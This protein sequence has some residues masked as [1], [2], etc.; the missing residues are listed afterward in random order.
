MKLKIQSIILVTVIL[1]ISVTNLMTT[2][3]VNLAVLNFYSDTQSNLGSGFSET[4]TE[5]LNK[6]ENI[7]VLEREKLRTIMSEIGMDINQKFDPSTGQTIGK[8]LGVDYLISGNLKEDTNQVI[9]KFQLF[10]VKDGT[11]VAEESVKGGKDKFF[12]LQ[13]QL[14]EKVAKFFNISVSEQAKKDLYFIP[15]QDMVSFEKFSKGLNLYEGNCLKEA[16]GFFHN[17]VKVDTGFLEAHKYFE[18]TARK[19]GKLDEFINIYENM[20]S[21]DPQNPILLNYLGNAYFDKKDMVK[22]ESL[23]KKAIEIAPSFGNPYNNLASVYAL[24]KR[25]KEAL[26]KFE[27]ALK[28]SDKKAPVYNN[29]GICYLNLGDENNAIKYFKKV[30]EL[31]PK[32]PDFIVARVKVQGINILVKSREKKVPGGIFGEIVLNSAPVFEIQT[33]AGG[34]SPVERSKI[35]AERLQNMITEG[36]KSYQV[37]VGLMN[38][39]VVLQS[40]GGEL[41]MTITKDVATR[42]GTT[43]ENLAK[44]KAEILKKIL[45]YSTSSSLSAG[46]FVLQDIYLKIT[47]ETLEKLKTEIDTSRLTKLV[48]KEMT[49]GKMQKELE[50]LNFNNDEIS[51]II[52][53]STS[54][55]DTKEMEGT[56]KEADCLHRGDAYYSQGNI[57]R[58]SEEYQKALTINPSFSPAQFCLGIISFDQKD[59]ENAISYFNKAIK[60]N[61]EYKDA[62]IWLGKTYITQGKKEKAKEAF[63]KV[64]ELEPDNSEVKSYLKEL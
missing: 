9:I 23:Y 6:L 46:G 17:S 11:L 41:I 3:N 35:I 4:L 10:D 42:E 61:S 26:E 15:T 12:Y 14:S 32:N 30:L 20:L 47:E 64:L 8:N 38:K 1:I 57:S 43:T 60:N 31:D 25:Y 53:Y 54:C 16:Y 22:A 18:Y 59:Y 56:S 50:K 45:D 44:H 21:S 49:K 28:Y 51:K 40:S 36:L 24:T 34:L 63:V 52:K 5:K 2:G 27:E 62:F 13:G 58:A 19:L 55:D 39:Q 37:E 33:A 29:M 48:N 7:N